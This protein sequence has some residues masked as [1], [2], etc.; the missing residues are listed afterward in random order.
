[1]SKI[2]KIAKSIVPFM[3]APSV[4]AAVITSISVTPETQGS[5][6]QLGGVF[7]VYAPPY[8]LDIS[9]GAGLLINP[10]LSYFGLHSHL[11]DSPYVPTNAVVSFSF[12]EPAIVDSLEIIQHGNGIT[13]IEGFVGDSP[14]TMTSIGNVFGTQGDVTGWMY[15]PEKFRDVFDFNNTTAG[16]Y[17]KFVIT[18][19]SLDWGY[20]SYNIT[21]LDSLNAAFGPALTA[22][23]GVPEPSTAVPIAGLVLGVCFRRTRQKRCGQR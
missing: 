4:H 8:P 15:F 3:L 12:S 7:S 17:Y 18:K 23:S 19:T 9:S 21:P 10:A 1:M 16:S 20:S 11:Y 22:P 13:R 14:A 5:G 2:L 6:T